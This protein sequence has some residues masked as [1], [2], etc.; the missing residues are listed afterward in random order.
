MTSIDKLE[1]KVVFG[2]EKLLSDEER[3]LKRWRITGG[4]LAVLGWLSLTFMFMAI[5]ETSSIHPYFL[6]LA[7]AGGVCI[8]LSIWFSTFYSQWPV[9][10]AYIDVDRVKE[11]AKE[12]NA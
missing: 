10:R 1:K 2:L 12:L 4:V 7:V 11:R 3:Q 9:L 6:V 5:F 8:G